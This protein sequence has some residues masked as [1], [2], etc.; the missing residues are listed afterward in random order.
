MKAK[1]KTPKFLKVTFTAVLV[2]LLGIF[3]VRCDDDSNNNPEP[4]ILYN[5]SGAVTYPGG[6]A[7]GAVIYLANSATPT[8]NY[9]WVTV[10]NENGQYSISDLGAGDYFIFVNFNTAN[11]NTR[12]DGVNFD[13]GAGATFTIENANETINVALSSSGQD[14]AEAVNTTDQGDWNSD[15]SHSNVDFSFAYDEANAT[16]TG[17]FDNFDRDSRGSESLRS[18]DFVRGLR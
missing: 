15:F 12:V 7:A 17:R 9:D 8:T 18:E 13:S 11:Q 1:V 2:I 10:A 16:Y 4:E 14:N 5:V 3:M 6:T